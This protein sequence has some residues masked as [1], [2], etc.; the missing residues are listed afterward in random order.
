MW[1]TLPARRLARGAWLCPALSLVLA[2][3]VLVMLGVSWWSAVAGAALLGC[4]IAAAWAIVA[5]RSSHRAI[6]RVSGGGGRHRRNGD[7]DDE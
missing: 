6:E 5:Q 7:P 4:L 3:G 2:T 1:R